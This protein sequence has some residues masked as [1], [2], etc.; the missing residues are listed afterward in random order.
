M[1]INWNINKCRRLHYT[2][3]KQISC[4]HTAHNYIN[5]LR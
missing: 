2:H 5:I 1:V 4:Q 3:A